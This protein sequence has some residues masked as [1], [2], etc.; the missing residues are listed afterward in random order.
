MFATDLKHTDE[1]PQLLLDFEISKLW[2]PSRYQRSFPFFCLSIVFPDLVDG[3]TANK[4]VVLRSVLVFLGLHILKKFT[5]QCKSEQTK[6]LYG[7]N[8]T[9]V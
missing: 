3:P 2:A 9:S 5:S 6:S 7:L 8:F 4:V 1:I